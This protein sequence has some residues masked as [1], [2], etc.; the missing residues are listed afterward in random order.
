[1]GCQME[2]K[3]LRGKG[4][5]K[6]SKSSKKK[7]RKRR[8]KNAAARDERTVRVGKMNWSWKSDRQSTREV[9]GLQRHLGEQNCVCVCVFLA[10]YHCSCH[11][12]QIKIM[13]HWSLKSSESLIKPVLF[14]FSLA[15]SHTLLHSTPSPHSPTTETPSPVVSLVMCTLVLQQSISCQR[16]QAIKLGNKTLAPSPILTTNKQWGQPFYHEKEANNWLLMLNRHLTG[17]GS[18]REGNRKGKVCLAWDEGLSYF[19]LWC[20]SNTHTLS[21]CRQPAVTK[22]KWGY[23]QTYSVDTNPRIQTSILLSL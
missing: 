10:E 12:C 5:G 2:K 23:S 19:T 1:M 17:P 16:Q 9:W 6:V 13:T 8:K 18:K 14:F 21:Q 3:N 20:S 11:D 7:K 4:Q 22:V 15:M